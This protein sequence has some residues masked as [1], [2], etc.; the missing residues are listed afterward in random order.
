M[1]GVKENR[2]VVSFCMW[3]IKILLP[4]IWASV[5]NLKG[6]YFDNKVTKKRCSLGTARM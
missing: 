3:G 2:V 6:V 4:L 5:P 1:A